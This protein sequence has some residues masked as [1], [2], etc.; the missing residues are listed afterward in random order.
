MPKEV[1]ITA[2][3]PSIRVVTDFEDCGYGAMIVGT[4]QTFDHV[5]KLDPIDI[6]LAPVIVHMVCKECYWVERQPV[7]NV[8]APLGR[9]AL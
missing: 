9:P 8:K 7:N 3:T 2:N 6:N 5:S 1:F 4:H